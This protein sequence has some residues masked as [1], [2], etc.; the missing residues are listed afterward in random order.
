MSGWRYLISL[1]WT[2]KWTLA[3]DFLGAVVVIVGL[4]QALALTLREIFDTLTG[5]A[6]TSLNVW[7]LCAVIVGIATARFGMRVG[8][9]TLQS[10]NEFMIGAL[11]QRNVLTYLMHMSGGRGLPGSPGE[12]VTR[13]RDDAS[14]VGEFFI[15]PKFIAS[16]LVFAAIAVVIMIR[17]SPFITLVGFVPFHGGTGRCQRREVS[18][19][20][21]SE[22]KPGGDRG[23]DRLPRRD[24]WLR[25]GYKGCRDRGSWSWTSSIA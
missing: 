12:A 13:F 7:T 18:Y 23:R 1:S 20:T 4:E 9:I 8:T 6:R 10:A 16:N 5:D 21:N 14:G 24:V 2:F 3:L 17:I 19:R 15:G 25:G 22:A 11:L